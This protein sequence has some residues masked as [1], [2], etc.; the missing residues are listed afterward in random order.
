MNGFTKKT[1]ISQKIL[2]R[3]VMKMELHKTTFL[4]Q[5]D[6]PESRTKRIYQLFHRRSRARIRRN[7][8]STTYLVNRSL[9]LTFVRETVWDTEQLLIISSSRHVF[10]ITSFE[11]GC[12]RTIFLTEMSS[13]T[14]VSNSFLL[15][16]I[17]VRT[18]TIYYITDDEITSAVDEHFV[19]DDRHDDP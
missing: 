5:R 15:T 7:L 19:S 16:M 10:L 18:T 4:F 8:F 14:V 2:V 17:V 11:M 1:L 9:S 6:T 3:S 12:L 13:R